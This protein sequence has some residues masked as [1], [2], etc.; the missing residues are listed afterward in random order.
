MRLKSFLLIIITM[1]SRILGFLRSGLTYWLFPNVLISDNLNAVLALPN[2][3]RKLLA[4]GSLGQNFAFSFSADGQDARIPAWDYMLKQMAWSVPTFIIMYILA[5]VYVNLF[6]PDQAASGSIESFQYSFLYIPFSALSSVPA[7]YLAYKGKNHLL[8]LGTLGFSITTITGLLILSILELGNWGL[9]IALGGAVQLVLFLLLAQCWNWDAPGQVRT[10][11]LIRTWFAQLAFFS[12]SLILFL[13]ILSLASKTAQEGLLTAFSI[14]Y[15]LIQLPIGILINVHSMESFSDALE[16][17][18]QSTKYYFYQFFRLIPWFLLLFFA[19]FLFE[20]DVVNVL[21]GESY[22]ELRPPH[23]LTMFSLSLPALALINFVQKVY[24]QRK[25]YLL[26][27]FLQFLGMVLGY[28]L[29]YH[30]LFWMW[31]TCLNTAAFI[32]ILPFIPKLTISE[33][34]NMVFTITKLSFFALPSIFILMVSHFV[35]INYSSMFRVT[36]AAFLGL[37]FM[38]I[39]SYVFKQKEVRFWEG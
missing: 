22:I 33:I 15:N 31:A 24:A 11:G 21:F 6:F 28:F 39:P 37:S 30:S 17:S 7:G 19:I 12:L 4:E 35:F 23:L 10:R 5:P 34:K 38:V 18:N 2:T 9:Y 25:Q 36:L 29:S 8:V 27:L 1:V 26:P 14:E 3:F 20:I 32:L 16:S 13:I